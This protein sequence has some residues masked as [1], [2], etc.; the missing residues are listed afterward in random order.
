MVI[1]PYLTPP[2]MYT[3]D[4]K[5]NN[6]GNIRPSKIA[7]AGEQT[8]KGHPFCEFVTLEYGCEQYRGKEGLT[9][10]DGVSP[11]CYLRKGCSSGA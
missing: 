5:R 2:T 10:A 6:P 3:T 9:S 4:I 7:W 11:F 1:H 8:H